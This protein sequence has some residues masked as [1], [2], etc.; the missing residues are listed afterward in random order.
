MVE[1]TTTHDE[2]SAVSIAVRRRASALEGRSPRIIAGLAVL[3]V[4][5][6]LAATAIGK[7]PLSVGDILATLWGAM[8]GSASGEQSDTVLLSIRLPRVLAAVLVGAALAA[9]G[10]AYQGLFRNPL[11][12]PDILGVSSGAGLGAVLGIFL[13]LSVVGIQLLAFAGG[14]ATVGLVYVIGN[15][16]RNREPVLVLVLAGVVVGSLAGAA[17]SLLKILA[18]PYDQLP[19]IVFW[20]LG[21]L[22]ST[23]GAEV[24]S[25]APL[26]LAGLVPLVLLRWRINVLSLGDEEAR[27]LGVEAGRLRLIVIAAATLM[28]ASVVA[29]A[30]VVG[31]I[32]LVIPHLARMLVGPNFN[33]LLPASLLM[34]GAYM[35]LIDTLARTVAAIEVPLGVLT[36]IIGAP[37][38][39]WL[40]ARGED[41]WS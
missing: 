17:I 40:L 3:L 30:G 8:T 34:G 9:A 25:A 14:L 33:R 15:L 36:A 31:W 1:G 13:S 19:A 24:W 5:M 16:V 32:G 18:D 39:L 35:L 4:G 22:S 20:L 28:T 26:V 23:R 37:F 2:K 12:S 29:V 38:F 21:S 27:A 7:Y 6:M 11:V 41:G 10:A